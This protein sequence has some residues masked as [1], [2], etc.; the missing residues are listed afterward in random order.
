M[1]FTPQQM[2]PV[3]LQRLA[4]S[5]TAAQAA[6]QLG[7]ARKTYYQWEVRALQGMQTALSAGRPGRPPSKGNNPLSR[8]ETQNQRL[9]EQVKVLEQRLRCQEVLN[10]AETRAKK[11]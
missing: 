5:L 1:L 11:K 8:M 2:M 4:G 6:Q 7:I 9:Q 10:S 3:I